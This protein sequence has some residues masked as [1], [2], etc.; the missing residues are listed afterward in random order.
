MNRPRLGRLSRRD[1]LLAAT[2]LTVLIA[3]IGLYA[4]RSRRA[5]GPDD[6]W[7]R[8][9][10]ALSAGRIDEAEAAAMS[11]SRLRD[12]TP[13]DRMLQAQIDVARSRPDE[14][15]GKL[16]SIPDDHPAAAQARLLAGQVELRRNRVRT[17]ERYLREAVRLDPKQIPAH[18]ELI[19]IYGYQLRRR[20]L[21]AEFHA[22][23]GLTELTF[24]N[25]FHWCLLRNSTWEPGEAAESLSTFIEA[26]PE[27][28]WS[29][30]ALAENYRL[31]GLTDEAEK[32]ILPLPESDPQARA[33]RVMLALDRHQGDKAQQ[34]LA[35]GDPL[36]PNLAR[37]RGRLALSHHD[38]PSAARF[39][40]IA[41]ADDPENRD[42][43]FGL[44]NALSIT[45][46]DAAAAPLRETAKR[47]ELLNTMIQQAASSQGRKK[48]RLLQELGAACAALGHNAEARAWYQVAIARDPLDA[49]AQRALFRLASQDRPNATAGTGHHHEPSRQ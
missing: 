22:L 23:A 11:L 20:E 36:D 6:L 37:L 8:G 14:S 27:D 48:P 24:E 21:N 9:Q 49:E 16:D 18:R 25:V 5:P 40:R 1:R 35:A 42:A 41:L 44:I 47:L 38:G 43:L 28:R 45:G 3:S 26:D 33:I 32:A 29:R 7:K 39:F 12:P 19:Y 30:L 13:W 10:G 4:L 17:A 2:A 15:L 46:D 31:M 34:M